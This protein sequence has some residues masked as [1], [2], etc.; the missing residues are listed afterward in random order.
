MLYASILKCLAYELEYYCTENFSN[1]REGGKMDILGL[2]LKDLLEYI[3]HQA[4]R[5]AEKAR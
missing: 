2:S 1:H 5:N 3:Q 4:R